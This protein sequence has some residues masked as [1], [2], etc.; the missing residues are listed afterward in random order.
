MDE[1]ARGKICGYGGVVWLVQVVAMIFGRQCELVRR[2][3]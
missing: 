3:S 2:L 1:R